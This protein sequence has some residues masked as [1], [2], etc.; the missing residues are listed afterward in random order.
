MSYLLRTRTDGRTTY[1]G[2][3]LDMPVD[4]GH[5]DAHLQRQLDVGPRSDAEP[6]QLEAACV[7]R[8]EAERA[9]PLELADVDRAVQAPVLDADPVLRLDRDDVAPAD[10][11]ATSPPAVVDA[12]VERRRA[13]QERQAEQ[14]HPRLVSR[15]VTICRR[16]RYVY[17]IIC[18][19]SPTIRLFAH[20]VEAPVE[21]F[22][23][24]NK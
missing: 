14:S 10:D 4:D 18:I 2:A 16:K 7:E 19:L 1:L 21:L 9:R 12:D 22:Y 13:G 24:R 5:L 20:T 3:Y 8:R 11:L 15:Y 6:H 23:V 17:I